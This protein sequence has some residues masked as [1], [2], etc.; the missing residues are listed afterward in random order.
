[1]VEPTT[2]SYAVLGLLVLR[3]FTAYELKQQYQ[4][5]FRY[6]WPRSEANLYAEPKRLVRLGWAHATSEQ[7]G[8]RSRTTYRI[9]ADGRHELRRWLATRPAAPALEIEGLV[10]LLHA[11]HGSLDDL[12]TAL[13]STGRQARELLAAGRAQVGEY[14]AG[15]GLF[16][17]REHILALLVDGYADIMA[18]LIGW[19]DRAVAEIGS[20]PSTTDPGCTTAA[21]RIF[22]ETIRRHCGSD[23]GLDPAE[24]GPAP[25]GGGPV[26]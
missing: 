4:R 6:V 19:C 18:A 15:A 26:R 2:T 22:A 10:R 17:E 14:E 16:P 5:T 8:N 23:V 11:D 1:M 3:P 21:R 20:W 24:D 9:T 7:V 13:E 12:R 25:P